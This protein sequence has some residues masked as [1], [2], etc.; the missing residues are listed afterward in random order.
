MSVLFLTPWM[1]RVLTPTVDHTFPVGVNQSS[2]PGVRLSDRPSVLCPLLCPLAFRVCF[3]IV[4]EYK[5][6]LLYVTRSTNEELDQREKKAL[7]L[8][9]EMSPASAVRYLAKQFE[10]SPRQ[11]RRYVKKALILS[12]D[13]P[14]STDELGFSIANNMERLERIADAAA[15]EGD[16]KTEIAATRAAIQAAESRLKAIQRHDETHQRLTGDTPINF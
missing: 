14:L 1:V 7:D 2:Q 13:A 6:S 16:R 4:L 10:V 12:F 15:T 11:A 8:L 3:V 9:D 5:P